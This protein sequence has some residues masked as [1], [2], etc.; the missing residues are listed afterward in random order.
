[1]FQRAAANEP[2]A[3]SAITPLDPTTASMRPGKTGLA[4]AGPNDQLR[5]PQLGNSH[6]SKKEVKTCVYVD[7]C[8]SV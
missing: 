3:C 7:V 6:A 8:A 5:P 1:M 4:A 2:N